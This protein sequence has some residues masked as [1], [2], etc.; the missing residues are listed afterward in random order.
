[1]NGLDF[2]RWRTAF[3]LS[4]QEL[5]EK[6]GVTRTTIQNWEAQSEPLNVFVEN[7][8]KIWD[9]RLRQEEPLRGPVTLVFADGPMLLP[10]HGP[11]RAAMM[12]QELH[13][14][15]AAVLARAQMLVGKP[16]FFNPFV[17]EGDRH[18][19]WNMVELQRAIDGEDDGAP[20]MCN[21]LR[22]LAADIRDNAPNF[23]RSGASIPTAQEQ[24]RRV[25]ELNALAVQLERIADGTLAEIIAEYSVVEAI[26]TQVRA[27]GIRPRDIYV[28][29]LAQG[30][31][32]TQMPSPNQM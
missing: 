25:R 29:G 8:V 6:M 30:C 15:N 5:A 26:L 7:A 14:S 21:L 10:A 11:R 31:H 27:L 19:L 12:Q 17:L 2:R 1:M 23:V 9:R 20:T 3:G 13:L 4:Q 16:F 22:W 24:K 18:D 32:A 28:S